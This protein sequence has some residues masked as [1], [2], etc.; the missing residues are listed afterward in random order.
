MTCGTTPDPEP[1]SSH[2][3]VLMR[4]MAL[5]QNIFY[6]VLLSDLFEMFI[7]SLEFI[8]QL[9]QRNISFVTRMSQLPSDTVTVH[10]GINA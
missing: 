2:V 1:G 5:G 9:M 4:A 7:Y 8:T 6:H 10:Q 3:T